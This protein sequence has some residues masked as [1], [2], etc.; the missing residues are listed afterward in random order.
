MQHFDTYHGEDDLI[1][2]LLKRQS[3]LN[4]LLEITRAINK[5]MATPILL[6]M[7]EMICRTHLQIGKLRFLVEND[8][9]FSCISRY[10]GNTETDAELLKSCRS[11][12]K[13][14]EPH[15]IRESKDRILTQYDYFIPVFQ[16]NK[17]IAYALIGDF[18]SSEEMLSN[19]LN[20]VQTLINM[21]WVALENKRL[22]AEQLEAERLQ[23]EM[24]LASEVQNML[25]PVQTYADKYIELSA[26]YLPHQNIGGDYFDF[27]CL[28]DQEYL[29]CIADVS[30][31]G[32]SAA[33]LMA[34]F[35]A[36]LRAWATVEDDL[37]TIVEQLNKIVL[38]NTKG[39]KFITLFIARYNQETRKLTYINAGHNPAILYTG[40]QVFQL[41]LG[42]TMIGTFEDLPFLNQGEIDIEPGTLIF[43]YTDGLLD[44][45]PDVSKIWNEDTLS[46]CVKK[47][48]HLQP[49][50]VNQQ[51]LNYLNEHV[52]AKPIDDV[53]ML[54]LKIF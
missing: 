23:R 38:K 10:G 4:S 1:R 19:D 18:H 33:L 6:Q 35:Q 25:I 42:T 45:E 22:F 39:E 3:E 13:I 50:K 12:K 20:F 53:T 27:F 49:G 48:G 46:A 44:R 16:K 15:P 36:S 26:R 52:K 30:G 37:A 8:G 28:N 14:Q 54:T 11:L 21:I 24:E 32:I 47:Y 31:K 29:W 2:L 41:K 40:K 51:I 17:A 5:N 9:H 34:N 7:F 43:N